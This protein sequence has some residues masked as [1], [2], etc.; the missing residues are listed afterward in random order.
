[1]QLVVANKFSHPVIEAISNVF[2]VNELNF[3]VD[4]KC[5]CF[6]NFGFT[7]AFKKIF[8]QEQ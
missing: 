5:P 4:A 3:K 2:K 8:S 6:G 1:V 7:A